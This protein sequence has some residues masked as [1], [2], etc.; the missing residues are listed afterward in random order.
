MSLYEKYR[1]AKREYVVLQIKPA[2]GKK[3]RFGYVVGA[4]VQGES[5]VNVKDIS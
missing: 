4:L 2:L 3:S 1:T 5:L